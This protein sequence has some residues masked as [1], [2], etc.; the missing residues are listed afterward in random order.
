MKIQVREARSTDFERLSA[1]F[2]E[3]NR[4]HAQLVPAYIQITSP[5]L[6]REELQAFLG[7]PTDRLFVCE[8]GDKLLGAV[9]V[10]LQESAEDRWNKS[11][12]CG[13]IDD[14]I[15]TAT[16]RGRGV[17]RQLMQAARRWVIAQGVQTIELHVWET[18]T[19]ARRFYASLGLQTV[20]H[21][22]T[23]ELGIEDD[24]EV[25]EAG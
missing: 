7:S 4:F 3:E 21:R 17:G 5:V 6:T 8:D 13:Y 19:D 10:S 23:W 16:A 25:H 24:D 22:M 2:A 15:V 9:I 14:L 18:N 1:L 20:Q 12:L 11:R